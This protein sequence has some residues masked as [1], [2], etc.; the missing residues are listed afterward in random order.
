MTN[1]Y[2]AYSNDYD[3][4]TPSTATLEQFAGVCLGAIP[5]TQGVGWIVEKG[6]TLVNTLGSTGAASIQPGGSLKCVNTKSYM[7]LDSAEGTEPAY[8]RTAWAT[9]KNTSAVS[10]DVTAI[11]RC[12]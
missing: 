8:A 9:T 12:L 1:D 6:V 7:S 2:G 5:A 10:A 3:V 4:I 11:I